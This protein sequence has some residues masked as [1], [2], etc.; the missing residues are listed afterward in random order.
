[1]ELAAAVIDVKTI[2][3]IAPLLTN[4]DPSLKENVSGTHSQIA[5]HSIESAILIHEVV[6]HTQELSQSVV[7]EGGG[8]TLVHFLTTELSNELLNAVTANGFIASFS[9]SLASASN[10]F[11]I[12][13][14]KHR[15]LFLCNAYFFVSSIFGE[16]KY[17]S[18]S[19]TCVFYRYVTNVSSLHEVIKQTQE[20]LLSFV[21]EVGGITLV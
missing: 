6:K 1:M 9:Q 10:P 8:V 3:H 21:N 13:P 15:F 11:P 14:A 16:L 20:L 7:N 19:K 18:H 4:S 17:H 5:K 2:E 12:S